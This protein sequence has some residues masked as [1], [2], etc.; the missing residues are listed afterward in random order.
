MVR[1]E[2]WSVKSLHFAGSNCSHGGEV[3]GPASVGVALMLSVIVRYLLPSILQQCQWRSMP[4]CN[5]HTGASRRIHK[6]EGPTLKPW[7]HESSRI[8][9]TLRRSHLLMLPHLTIN[10]HWWSRFLTVCRFLLHLESA[11]KKLLATGFQDLVFEDA[12]DLL[13]QHVS[14]QT[15]ECC[16]YMCCVLQHVWLF[17]LALRPAVVFSVA[18]CTRSNVPL[19]AAP[20][21]VAV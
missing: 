21:T 7:K 14:M 19:F 4:R 9:K 12:M 6:L 20:A 16:S 2:R 13:E 11:K 3:K 15:K 17:E 5:S 1:A 10:S 18:C 8:P